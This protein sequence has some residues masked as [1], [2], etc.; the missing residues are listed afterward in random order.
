[1]PIVK[2]Y[3][4]PHP[5]LIIP[6]IGRGEEEKIQKTI[7]SYRKIAMEIA[8]I[9]PDTIIL[10]SPHSTLYADYFH[11]SP[12]KSAKG[13]LSGFRAGHVKANVEYDI[14]LRDAIIDMA[15][16][17][18]IQLGTSGEK[19]KNL[20]HGSMIPLYFIQKEYSNFKMIRISP[21]GFS[22][23]D[24]YDVGKLIAQVIPDRLKVVWIASG[25]LS[26]KLKVDGPYGL[27]EEGLEF[28]KLMNKH[29]IDQ[30]FTKLLELDHGF[31]RKAAECGLGSICMMLGLFDET[32]I[33]TEVLSYEGPFGV[34][35]MVA[36]ISPMEE[37]ESRN[38]GFKYHENLKTVLETK[39]G[40]EDE[41]VK[42]AR[43]SLEYYIIN[44]RM[45]DIP[46]NLG[47][48]LIENRAGVFVSL[49]LEGRLRGCIGTISPVT[50]CVAEEI[51]Q[52]AVSSGTRDYRFSK[53]R[54]SE[55][56]R[57]DYSVDVLM[58]AE[59]ITRKAEL[60]VKR[61]GLIV[62]SGYKS[63]LLLPNIDG[64]DTID[65]QIR[66][67]KMK[68]GIEDYEAFTMERFEVIRHK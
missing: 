29:I 45:M 44:H 34:G 39:K 16:S 3:I 28:D 60:D 22:L 4:V 55:L 50:S 67:S 21:S 31:C 30:D 65:E 68:A 53:V 64:V 14:D 40:N 23:I 62:R 43:E 11:V 18:K 48:D 10:S 56:S 61:Y 49:H 42:L 8:E 24:H 38:I 37:D 35:Y 54:E 17:K 32:K 33:D 63:G 15:K 25:D 47:K 13:D 2:A 57:I 46:E 1:M 58:P 36:R 51:I 19:D 26:H 12:G 9:K 7:D 27:S 59:P 5:P 52:N 20:D 6:D 41:Y 66:I